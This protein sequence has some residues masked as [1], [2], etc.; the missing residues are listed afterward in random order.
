MPSAPYPAPSRC[1]PPPTYHHR[2]HRLPP[3]A[4][5]KAL[6][7]VTSLGMEAC[8]AVARDTLD[9]D[10]PRML[11][12]TLE[13]MPQLQLRVV[14]GSSSY[15]HDVL[16]LPW[17]LT[18]LSGLHQLTWDI[19]V[20]EPALPRG[21]WLHSLRRLALPADVLLSNED[22]LRELQLDSLGALIPKDRA[23]YIGAPASA[24]WRPQVLRLAGEHPT[25]RQLDM[26][27]VEWFD[28]EELRAGFQQAKA[29]A[30]LR[31][32]GLLVTADPCL[33]DRRLD[34]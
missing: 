27:H 16:E 14:W 19:A 34:E 10:I 5:L 15:N 23:P 13:A 31:R 7:G 18:G 1:P 8:G 4:T 28:N 26:E 24:I 11:E 25:L 22:T 32:P 30:M 21:A 6:T 12:D 20:R 2:P 33:L 29:A 9:D 17:A 3:Y